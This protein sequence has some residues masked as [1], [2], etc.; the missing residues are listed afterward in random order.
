MYNGR[1]KCL[2]NMLAGIRTGIKTIC[3]LL[4]VSAKMVKTD[5]SLSLSLLR[6]KNSEKNLKKQLYEDFKKYT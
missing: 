3:K 5:Y 4:L 1:G 2:Q 6:T